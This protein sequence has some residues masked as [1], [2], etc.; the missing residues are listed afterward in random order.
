MSESRNTDD[1]WPGGEG[2]SRAVLPPVPSE[3]RP[4]VEGWFGSERNSL[5][6]LPKVPSES[7]ATDDGCVDGSETHQL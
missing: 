1:G 5:A 3:S 6:V 7:R 2:N 4:K